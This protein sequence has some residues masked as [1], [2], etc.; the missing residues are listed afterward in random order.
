MKLL[1]PRQSWKV[2]SISLTSLQAPMGPTQ[3]V[4]A[5]LQL[6]LRHLEFAQMLES[7]GSGQIVETSHSP[8]PVTFPL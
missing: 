1:G 3:S 2:S 6:A 7:A 8:G 5:G 4:P